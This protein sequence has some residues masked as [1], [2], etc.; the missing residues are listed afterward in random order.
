MRVHLLGSAGQ[1]RPSMAAASQGAVAGTTGSRLRAPRRRASDRR[2]ALPRRDPW[3]AGNLRDR[4]ARRAD[5]G[6]ARDHRARQLG[7]EARLSPLH[8]AL[9]RCRSQGDDLRSGPPVARHHHPARRGRARGRVA[10]A[11]VPQP[12]RG[13]DARGRRR[14]PVGRAQRCPARSGVARELDDRRGALG[15][16]RHPHHPVPGRLA[17]LDAPDPPRHQRVRR[18]H[19]RPA[20]Q[21]PDDVRRRRRVGVRDAHGVRTTDGAHAQELRLGR[22]PPPRRPDDP[23]VRGAARAAPGPPAGRG[24]LPHARALCHAVDDRRRFR[25][26]RS[27]CRRLPALADHGTLG[28]PHPERRAR[29]L[30]HPAVARAARRLRGRDQPRDDGVRRNRRNG[31]VPSRRSRRD[32][33]R[34]LRGLCDRRRRDGVGRRGD[35]DARAAP[36]RFV[37]RARDRRLLDRGRADAVQGVRSGASTRR[38]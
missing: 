10:P 23:A 20:A 15:P 35:R 5:L 22:Q 13:V 19:V 9:L 34:G 37:P 14:S 26:R 8:P 16:R 2:A 24:R 25:R 18:G 21:P 31:V 28:P 30:D 7:V 33:P 3:P 6:A 12:G 1:R 36:A 32:Q 11:P 29:G 38:H 27:R 4:E 17:Q